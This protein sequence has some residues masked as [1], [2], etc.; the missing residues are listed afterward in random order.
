MLTLKVLDK[1]REVLAEEK[2]K[3]IALIYSKEYQDGDYIRVESSI[4]KFVSLKQI[5]LFPEQV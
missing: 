5:Y 2:G 4:D 3:N 1:N